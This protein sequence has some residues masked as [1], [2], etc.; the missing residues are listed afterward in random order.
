MTYENACELLNEK[1]NNEELKIAHYDECCKDKWKKKKC[2][3]L[4][5]KG[6]CNKKKVKKNCMES[7]NACTQCEDKWEEQTCEK[8]KRTCKC[9]KKKVKKNCMKTCNALVGDGWGCQVATTTT[10]TTFVVDGCDAVWAPVCG[11]NG[12]SYSCFS[13]QNL[14]KN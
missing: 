13:I 10:T 2:K 7:C 11:T 9:D 8:L 4:V 1:C 14:E 12:K 3:K 5:K 6:K